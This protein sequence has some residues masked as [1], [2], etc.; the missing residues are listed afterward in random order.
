[1]RVGVLGGG[2]L[3]RMLGLAGIPLGMR[4][5]FLEPAPEPPAGAV[6]E[7]IPGEYTD[8]T[9]LDLLMEVVDLVTYEFENVPAASTARLLDAGM[10]VLPPPVALAVAQDRL[11]E[12]ELFGELGIPTPRYRCVDSEEDLREGASELG[13]PA[14]LKTRRMG[15]DGKGQVVIRGP[16]D[17]ERAWTE[18]APRGALLLEGFVAFQRELSVVAVR[19]RDGQVS[20]YPLVENLHQGGILVRTTAPAARVT[21]ELA[22]TAERYVRLVMEKLGY[23]GVMALELFQDGEVLLA[24]EVAPRVHNSGHWTQDGAR[25]SQFENH[26]RAVTGLPLGSTRAVGHT[27]ML[28]LLGSL[29]PLEAVLR[30]PLAHLHLY[31]K[32]ERP[33]RKVGHINVSGEDRGEVEACAARILAAANP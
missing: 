22:E 32:K 31:G 1:M 17:L 8:P 30:E 29:P 2:Q 7:L 4:F 11:R 6:G 10:T 21:P 23:V 14:I 18:L 9:A 5:H 24:N 27:V 25:V 12:K 20:A 33:G 28:N 15:Y 13:F 16:D 19:G 26:L 3:G